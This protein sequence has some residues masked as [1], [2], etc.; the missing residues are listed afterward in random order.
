MSDAMT[1]NY[2]NSNAA[3]FSETTKNVDFSEVQQIFTNY[4]SLDASVLDFGCGSGRDTRYFID[5]GYH[6]TAT[7]G[8]EVI[9][10]MATD[11][12]GIQVKQMLFEELDDRNQY[13]GIWACASILHLSREELPDIFRKMHRALKKNGIIYTSFKYGTFEGERNG[14]YFTDFTEELFE[15]FARQI[16]GL[17]I[18]KMW[19]TGD[20]REGRDDE[21]W[22]NILLRKTDIC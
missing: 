14:R 6:V 2:Y 19:I 12:T 18:E 16:S 1:L 15:E 13:D 4:L 11:Y 10:K 8:S 3:V 20:V 17:Q 21:R 9:C 22:L 5:H 7:D